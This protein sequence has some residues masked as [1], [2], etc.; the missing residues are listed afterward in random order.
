MRGLYYDS[1]NTCIQT[2]QYFEQDRGKRKRAY[3]E[4]QEGLAELTSDLQGMQGGTNTTI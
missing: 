1:G 4:L 2:L 3:K